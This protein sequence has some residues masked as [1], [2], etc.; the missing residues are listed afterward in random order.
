MLRKTKTAIDLNKALI[1]QP[2]LPK[3]EGEERVE[4]QQSPSPF[5]RG[6]FPKGFLR[7]G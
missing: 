5:G 4:I 6:L 3:G 2:L 7:K 1:P